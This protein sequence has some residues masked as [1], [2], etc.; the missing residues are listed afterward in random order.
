MV[1]HGADPHQASGPVP[2]MS[3]LVLPPYGGLHE[4]AGAVTPTRLTCER[5]RRTARTNPTTARSD[6]LRN[7]PKSHD[8]M[9]ADAMAPESARTNPGMLAADNRTGSDTA[10]SA[11][12][13]AA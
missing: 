2:T 5:S 6:V 7:E 13:A 3:R 12:G 10:R 9:S 11:G 8:R 1:A 4:R